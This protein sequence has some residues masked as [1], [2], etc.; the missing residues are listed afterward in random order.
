MGG[1]L[2][3][4]I[5]FPLAVALVTAALVAVTVLPLYVTLDMADARRFSTARWFV[6]S[7]VLIVLGLGYAYLLHSHTKVST[8]VA[9]L[10]LILT[11]GGPGALWL[12]DEGQTRIGGRAGRHE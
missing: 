2:V 3:T 12:M 8:P 11:W 10:P 7:A 4:L 5:V 9:L 6:A 1:L